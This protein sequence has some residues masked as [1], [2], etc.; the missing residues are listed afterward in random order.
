MPTQKKV[1]ILLSDL[2]PM[3]SRVYRN[4][5]EAEESFKAILTPSYKEALDTIKKEK[6]ALI[7]TDIILEKGNGFDLIREV[8]KNS[9]KKQ[10]KTPIIILTDLGAESD[11]KKAL[12]L[13]ANDYLIK[14]ELTINDA[15]S[16]IKK[17]LK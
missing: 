9:D 12:D 5:F 11:Q 3:L 8:R 17:H 16:K 15:I 4:K 1:L 14:T 6:P 13:G 7:V 10:A 2:N